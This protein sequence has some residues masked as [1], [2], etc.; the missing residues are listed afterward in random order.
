MLNK[1]NRFLII[2]ACAVSLVGMSETES[3]AW[4]FLGGGWLWGSY[5]ATYEI[6]GGQK[7]GT[8]TT[9][10]ASEINVLEACLVCLNPGNNRKDVR[11]GLGGITVEVFSTSDEF[12]YDERGRYTL[13]QEVCSTVGEG[14]CDQAYFE[15]FWGVSID[16]CRNDNWMP[17]QFL[18]N[19]LI[20]SGRILTDCSIDEYGNPFDW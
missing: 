9:F 7:P 15:N 8:L 19:R 6:A 1:F 5:E 12:Q 16:D 20:L 4:S 10:V 17:Y 18:V 14:E 2:F 11:K 13:E 3:K